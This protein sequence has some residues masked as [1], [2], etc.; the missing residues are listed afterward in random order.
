MSE[1]RIVRLAANPQLRLLRDAMIASLPARI[2]VSGVETHCMRLVLIQNLGQE[3]KSYP[4][5]LHFLD[6]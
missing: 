3:R 6:R 2:S 5:R 4:L 1:S